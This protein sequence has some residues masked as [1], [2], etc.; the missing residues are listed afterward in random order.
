[1]K[2][3]ENHFTFVIPV[4]ESQKTLP[5]LVSSLNDFQ[6]QHRNYPF[7]V[8]FIYDASTDNSAEELCRL[9]KKFPF[10]IHA[11]HQNHGQFTATAYGLSLVKTSIAITIDDDLQHHPKDAIKLIDHHRQTKTSLVYGRLESKKHPFLR[12]I[13]ALTLRRLLLLTGA[14]YAGVSSFRLLD[15]QL[16]RHF[17]QLDRKV[18]FLDY[19]LRQITTSQSFIDVEH[20]PRQHTVSSYSTRKLI[21]LSL[22]ML[23]VHTGA[24]LK[25]I[26]RLGLTI[27]FICFGFGIYF[28]F[29]KIYFNVPIGYTSIIVSTLF[30][31]GLVLFSLGIIGEYIRK[32][33][34]H[35]INVKTIF[36]RK[37]DSTDV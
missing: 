30:S 29:Q 35:S 17:N 4:F 1:M 18:I 12:N 28:L 23:F 33:W 21:H 11:F 31:S 34:L 6:D 25:W 7:H 16:L 15:Q 13:G 27:A 8:I 19:E 26:S 37:L 20:Y 24:P 2:H 36:A 10:E 5:R 3:S 14:N 22:K 32:I 9:E